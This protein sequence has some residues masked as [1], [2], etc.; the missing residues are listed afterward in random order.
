MDNKQKTHRW[1]IWVGILAALVLLILG[2]LYFVSYKLGSML[3]KKLKE[4]ITKSSEGLYS[5]EYSD[6]D[7]N[8]VGGNLTLKDILLKNDS[9]AYIKLDSAKKAPNT[10]FE[11]RADRLAISGASVWGLLVNKK[12]DIGTIALDSLKAK[13]LLRDRPYN[14]KEEKD[15]YAMIKDRF[16]SWGVDKFRANGI[17]LELADLNMEGTKPKKVKG[18]DIAVYNFLID[19]HS[20]TD[21]TRFLYSKDISLHIPGF[22]TN[23]EGAP[24]TFSFKDLKFSSK[25]RDVQISKLSLQPTLSLEA[26]AKQDKLNKPRIELDLDST[27]ITGINMQKLLAEKLF[28]ADSAHVVAGVFDLSKDKRYQLENVSKVGQSPAQQ[29]MKVGLPF[30]VKAVKVSGIDLSYAQISDKYF[31][32]GK[33]EFKNIWGTLKNVSNDTT[34]LRRNKFMT[35]ELVGNIYGEGRLSAFFTFD[36]LSKAGNHSYKGGLT[37]MKVGAYNRILEPLLN[38]RLADGNIEKIT[39]DMH[40]NDVKNWGKFRFDY[41]HLKVDV[42]KHPEKGP[43][44]KGILSFIANKFFINDSNPDANGKY[45]VALVDYERNPNHPFF[46]VVWHSLLQ[47][48]IECTGTDPK[49]LAL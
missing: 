26:F 44:K 40:G 7:L 13:V 29:F 42:L 41:N 20:G 17:A 48:I 4:G 22:K 9:T 47:G 28:E 35:A 10:R 33:I 27:W 21:S 11:A 3:D 12:I 43:G 19:E 23:L 36:M 5:I 25:N 49:Y 18:V 6:L 24:Y 45:H 8:I 46:K 38:I 30:S 37:A 2:G 39:F 14:E 1:K 15:S 34:V 31:R 16:K 32:E